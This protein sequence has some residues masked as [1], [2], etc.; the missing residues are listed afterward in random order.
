MSKSTHYVTIC[1]DGAIKRH[2]VKPTK[3]GIVNAWQSRGDR[4]IGNRGAR[5]W[6]WTDLHC[7]IDATATD[8]DALRAANA[9]RIS[10]P[11]YMPTL[12]EERALGAN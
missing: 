5:F 8:L 6:H 10:H 9:M 2:T 7:A 1:R 3:N 4:E 11:R 12:A